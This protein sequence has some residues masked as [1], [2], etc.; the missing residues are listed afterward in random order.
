MLTTDPNKLTT[1][2]LVKF[3]DRET[4]MVV[5][6]QRDRN[7]WFL[8]GIR[9]EFALHLTNDRRWLITPVTHRVGTYPR[10]I[11]VESII[12]PASA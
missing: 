3:A 10:E 2:C 12:T 6:A 4:P 5:I 8:A 1:G 7:V 11:Q 9:K